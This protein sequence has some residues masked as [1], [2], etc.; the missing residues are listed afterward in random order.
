LSSPSFACTLATGCTPYC[1]LACT[2]RGDCA[3]SRFVCRSLPFAPA[4]NS[5]FSLVLLAA[6]LFFSLVLAVSCI[7]CSLFA[8]TLHALHV[9]LWVENRGG[10][11]VRLA[12]RG[13]KSDRM[14]LVRVLTVSARSLSISREC[15]SLSL[16]S[17]LVFLVFS[18]FW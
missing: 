16:V 14:I 6:L 11:W 4:L 9:F 15:C 3:F 17:F 8:C 10:G 7:A 12:V 1:L 5:C 2:D 13:G 18:L